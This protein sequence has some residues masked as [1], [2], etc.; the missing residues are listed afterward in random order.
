MWSFTHHLSWELTGTG[1]PQRGSHSSTPEWKWNWSTALWWWCWCLQ[2]QPISR[3][4]KYQQGSGWDNQ[5][6][7][8]RGLFSTFSEK[9]PEVTLWT[10]W[11][12]PKPW[13]SL[14]QTDDPTLFSGRPSW[15]GNPEKK[16]QE[17]VK[18]LNTSPDVTWCFEQQLVALSHLLK[19][20]DIKKTWRI[21]DLIELI[22][23][24][25]F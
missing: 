24:E 20:E 23:C 13:T 10:T 11:K 16:E 12:Q 19:G 14:F 3:K 22:G 1:T 17:R 2:T 6:R 18:L 9:N 4:Q 25:G 15:P 21:F 8:K 5:I 7:I